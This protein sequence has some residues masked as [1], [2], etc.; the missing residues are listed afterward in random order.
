METSI[1]KESSSISIEYEKG[2][3]IFL[4]FY[5]EGFFN[6]EINITDIA[7]DCVIERLMDENEL[8]IGDELVFRRDKDIPSPLKKV[9]GTVKPK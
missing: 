4:R 3:G 9:V 5:D 8:Q 2:K 7:Q 6:N 1:N